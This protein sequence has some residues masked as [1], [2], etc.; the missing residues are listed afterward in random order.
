MHMYGHFTFRIADVEKKSCFFLSPGLTRVGATHDFDF[1]DAIVVIAG[2]FMRVD[3]GLEAAHRRSR[4]A[5]Q[6]G[7]FLPS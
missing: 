4:R 3:S 7:S 1:R 2:N 5:L 6:L